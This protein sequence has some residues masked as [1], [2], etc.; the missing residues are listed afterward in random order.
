MKTNELIAI[1]GAYVDVNAPNFPLG[2]EGLSLESEVVG[3][4]YILEPGGSAVNFARLCS[5]LEV[6][7]SFVGK[8]GKD[9]L[10]SIL[11]NLL[12]ESQVEPALVVAEDVATNVSFN[13]ISPDGKSIMAVVG[14]ANQALTADEV[15][16]KVSARMPESSYL[17]IGGCFKL[18]KLM[19]AFIQLAEDANAS[20][21]KVVLDHAR[22]NNGVTEDE[23]ETVRQLALASDVYLPS[24]DEFKELWGADSIE[25][26]ITLLLQKGY[27]GT[28]VV[29]DGER[30]VVS[31]TDGVIVHVPA[32]PVQPLHTVGAGDSFNAGFIAS[33]YKD[34]DIRQSLVFG[35]ATAA[36]KISRPALPTYA[37]V[38][39]FLADNNA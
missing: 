30:G 28:L 37:D 34:Q 12:V 31:V 21:T 38:V 5:A 11:T 20:G 27:S 4:E 26:G 2:H 36:L 15:Y 25:A 9:A 6:P 1:G 33:Q 39:R 7:A 24:A 32:F 35:C 19:P 14:T 8:V 13:M 16:T 17:F 23:K 3:Q 29:K 22:I 18:N 10:G